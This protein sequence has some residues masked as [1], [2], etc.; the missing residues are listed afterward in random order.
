MYIVALIVGYDN[1]EIIE[2]DQ[3]WTEIQSN[4]EGGTFLRITA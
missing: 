4:I 3:D 1:A 2:I